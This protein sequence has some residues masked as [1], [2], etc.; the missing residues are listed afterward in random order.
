MMILTI[1]KEKHKGNL[2]M[3]KII[4]T[5]LLLCTVLVI[6]G[7]EKIY[8]AEEFKKNKELRSEWAFK[9]LTGESSKNC[10]TVREAINEIEIEN[11]NN[12]ME[13]LKKQLE[14]DR[15]KFEKRR[16]EMER[17]KELRNE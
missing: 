13:E 16:K 15:K 5:I 3:N 8:S 4:M 11:R 12:R 14:E 10:E 6:T 9:C 7:C 17:K 1:N 2:V